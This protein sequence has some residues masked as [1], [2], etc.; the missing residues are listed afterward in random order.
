MD[1]R[2]RRVSW[3]PEF[4]SLW[5]W[6]QFD[7]LPQAPAAVTSPQWWTVF[8]WTIHQSILFLQVALVRIVYWSKEKSDNS[9]SPVSQ[10]FQVVLDAIVW[11][12]GLQ[13]EVFMLVFRT[14]SAA[15]FQNATWVVHAENTS[16]SP[17]I[18]LL[19][20]CGCCVSRNLLPVSFFAQPHRHLNS[21]CKKLCFWPSL[22]LTLLPTW[23]TGHSTMEFC[24]GE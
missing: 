14:K 12:D 2:Q 22:A 8:L 23:E 13:C 21:S 24:S 10:M 9:V 17:W 6:T 16:A 3:G 7:Q 18:R 4:F 20:N 5:Q 15:K 1:W 11:W 19:I